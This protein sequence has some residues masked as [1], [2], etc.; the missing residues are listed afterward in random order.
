[1]NEEKKTIRID[2]QRLHEIIIVHVDG[3]ECKDQFDPEHY[4]ENWWFKYA[5]DHNVKSVTIDEK[6]GPVSSKQTVIF[7]RNQHCCNGKFSN[8]GP[9]VGGLYSGFD[10]E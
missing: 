6:V 9:S 2:S 4:S 7:E 1:M 10:N 5:K 8:I 3:E